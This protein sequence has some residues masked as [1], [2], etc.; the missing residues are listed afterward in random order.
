MF[1]QYK[2][3]LFLTVIVLLLGT[4]LGKAADLYGSG[5]SVVDGD[6]F[7]LCEGEACTD[8]R[9]CGIDTPSRGKRGYGETI[10]ALTNLVVNKQIQCRP[11]GEGSVCDG[12]SGATSRGRTIAQCFVDQATV[13]VAGALVSAGLGCDRTDQSGGYYSKDHPEWDCQN[14]RP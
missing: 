9:L 3:L 2:R 5:Q 4:D 11:I 13:D 6:E 1:K 8:I 12:R 10:A 14:W 7:I